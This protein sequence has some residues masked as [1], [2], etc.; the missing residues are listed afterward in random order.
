MLDKN[1]LLRHLECVNDEAMSSFCDCCGNTTRCLNP[2]YYYNATKFIDL[3]IKTDIKCYP[4]IQQ[5]SEYIIFE[6]VCQVIFGKKLNW[7]ACQQNLSNKILIPLK[8]ICICYVVFNVQLNN[9]Y[10][11]KKV[12]I[13]DVRKGKIFIRIL[14][15][16]F[17]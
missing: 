17:Y 12:L 10:P 7:M 15:K 4:D 6:W 16:Q 14:R 3:L 9:K 8:I 2:Q 13:S 1:I 11:Q 5:C